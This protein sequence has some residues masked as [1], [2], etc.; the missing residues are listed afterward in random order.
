MSVKYEIIGE[1]LSD[2]YHTFGELYEHRCLLFINWVLSDGVPG[3]VFYVAEHYEGWDLILVETPVGQISY[4][5]PNK[6]APL[7]CEIIEP[8]AKSD[9][10]YDGH[11]SADVI[12]RLTE[13]AKR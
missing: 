4:H 7:Y 10:V 6:F 13:L 2:G 5:V 11:T 8:R 12:K 3:P 1:D 9:Y